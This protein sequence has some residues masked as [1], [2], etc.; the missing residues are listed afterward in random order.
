[1]WEPQVQEFSKYYRVITL[2]LRGHGDSEAPL[3]HFTLDDFAE[4]I[5]E[6]LRHLGIAQATCV[7]LSMGGYTLLA[8]FRKYPELIT[9]MVLADTRAQADSDEAKAGRFAMAQVAYQKGPQAIAEMMM[10]K[11]LGP[12]SLEKRQDIVEHIRSIIHKNPASGIIVDL[13]AMAQRP[14]SSPLLSNI[15]CPTLVIVGEDDVATPPAEAHYIKDRIPSAELVVL[16]Q[17]GHLSNLE[18]PQGF[19]QALISFFKKFE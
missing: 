5:R 10:P 13:M 19:N 16:P 15:S 18:Q 2:D 14:D 1:M 17:A 9:K 12:T 11:L 6:L 7:G 3:W 8:L 4:D